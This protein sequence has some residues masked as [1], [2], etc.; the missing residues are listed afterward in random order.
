MGEEFQQN[1]DPNT[2]P[3]EEQA[4]N[5]ENEQGTL[6]SD[7]THAQGTEFSQEPA[8]FVEESSSS[9]TEPAAPINEHDERVDSDAAWEMAY[10]AK[11]ERDGASDNR[12]LANAAE[13]FLENPR[14]ISIASSA[15]TAEDMK[16]PDA[17]TALALGHDNYRNTYHVDKSNYTTSEDAERVRKNAQMRIN[18]L[19]TEAT[20]KDT[21][22]EGVERWTQFL[23]THPVSKAYQEA[24]PNIRF[25]PRFLYKMET[26]ADSDLAYADDVEAL[27]E[28]VNPV[29]ILAPNGH[30]DIGKDRHGNVIEVEPLV[31]VMW[32]A[33]TTL[34]VQYEELLS[35]HDT[36]L[37]QIAA[38]YKM[39]YVATEL[40]AFRSSGNLNK[41]VVNDMLNGSATEQNS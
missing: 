24:H 5:Q 25:S 9:T 30:I 39:S 36:T 33:D 34:R 20:E 22:A 23:H 14:S 4:S 13:E 40:E 37:G 41:N 8:T 2:L 3:H 7:V 10:S 26:T 17:L 27:L 29:A 15:N 18:E 35:N 11:T 28:G 38:F 1:Q 31:Q 19:R 32:N 21:I 16:K 6:P 12:K